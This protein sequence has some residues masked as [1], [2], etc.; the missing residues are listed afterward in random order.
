MTAPALITFDIF[1]TVVDWKTG[2]ERAC[3]A[4]GRPLATGEFDAIIDAQ[5]AL[6]QGEYDLYSSIVLK[7][8]VSVLG[9]HAEAAAAIAAEVGT[10]PLFPDSREAL[11]RLQR[12]APCAAITNS[13]RAH[14]AQ[15]RA[16]LGFE[17]SEWLCAEDVRHYKPSRQMWDALAEKRGI[18][19]GPH[20][21]HVSAYGDYDLATARKLGLTTVFVGRPHQRQAESDV[22]VPNLRALAAMIEARA[23]GKEASN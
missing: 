17:L 10:W 1:G 23:A 6:E 20:W 22:T 21:W 13:D 12:I 2:L 16:Q 4:H 7:S 5:G 18:S 9:M 3:A 15:V 8:L 19:L 11:E 14:G